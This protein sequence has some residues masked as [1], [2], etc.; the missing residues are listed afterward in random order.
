MTD[1]QSSLTQKVR[2]VSTPT[3]ILTTRV[4]P[5]KVRTR[6]GTRQRTKSKYLG[7]GHLVPALKMKMMVPDVAEF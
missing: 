4:L 6:T 2:K 5:V 3:H 7:F 1:A